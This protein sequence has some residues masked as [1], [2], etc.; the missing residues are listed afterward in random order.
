MRI[1]AWVGAGVGACVRRVVGQQERRHAGPVGHD[2]ELADGQELE[3][4][5]PRR[6]SRRGSATHGP[7]SPSRCIQDGERAVAL[8]ATASCASELLGQGPS[9]NVDPAARVHRVGPLRPAARPC[10]CRRSAPALASRGGADVDATDPRRPHC[11]DAQGLARS[12]PAQAR[13]P[14]RSA[15]SRSP[16]ARPS[17]SRAESV[18]PQPWRRRAASGGGVA[19]AAGSL[20]GTGVLVDATRFPPIDSV[21]RRAGAGLQGASLAGAA[22]PP[23]RRPFPGLSGPQ[24]R[25]RREA[26]GAMARASSPSARRSL[27]IRPGTSGGLALRETGPLVPGTNSRPSPP[28]PRFVLLHGAPAGA[29]IGDGASPRRPSSPQR[30]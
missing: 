16:D 25:R 22:Y 1:L 23:G 4:S 29:R 2:G 7:T 15:C 18:R 20:A 5:G 30:L 13:C 28:Q 8:S 12:S 19:P 17:D 14:S 3:P 11:G 9:E 24:Q 21:A 26:R 10:A 27:R 6:G